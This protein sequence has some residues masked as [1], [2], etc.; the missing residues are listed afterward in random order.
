V[1]TALRLARAATGRD[2]V[3]PRRPHCAAVEWPRRGELR[4]RPPYEMIAKHGTALM[5]G[6]RELGERHGLPLHVQGFP[7]AFTVRSGPRTQPITARCP[8]STAADTPN[9]PR[10]WLSTESGS[11]P[12][13][14]GT[15]WPAM[16]TRNSKPSW[17]VSNSRSAAEA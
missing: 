13:A 10:P 1:H 3:P 5:N 4:E 11:P 8:A 15:C 16:A 14:S 17:P 7:A 2:K 6:I 12:G 9:S